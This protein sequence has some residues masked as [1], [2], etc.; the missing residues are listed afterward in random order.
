MGT[1]LEKTILAVITTARDKVGGSS[2]IF[3]ANDPKELQST[4]FT[5]EKILDGIAHEVTQ[6]TMII[7][8][9]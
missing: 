8:R 5:L 7:V 3:Y 9:H 4:A 6:E 1:T 2:P